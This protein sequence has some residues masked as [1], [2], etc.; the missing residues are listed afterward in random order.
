MQSHLY[1]STRLVGIA[2]ISE[3]SELIIVIFCL[4]VG[5]PRVGSV[6]RVRHEHRKYRKLRFFLHFVGMAPTKKS[7]IGF[8]VKV[9]FGRAR[10]VE[11]SGFGHF[12]TS[13]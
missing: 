2:I 10:V 6:H 7:P 8:F 3:R 4:G 1:I 9:S 11:G 12:C 5:N 13:I